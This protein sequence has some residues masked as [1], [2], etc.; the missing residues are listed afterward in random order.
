MS[1]GESPEIV[2]VVRDDDAAS[3]AN[4]RG[5]DQRVDS[6]LASCPGGGEQAAGNSRHARASGHDADAAARQDGIDQLVATPTPGEL[7]E[8]GRRDPYWCIAR[9]SAAHRGP[10]PLVAGPVETG[11]SESGHGL[12]IED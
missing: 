5:D 1:G 7:D 10:Y 11:P 9:V 2:G 4:R 6:D 3:E 8:H 12:A